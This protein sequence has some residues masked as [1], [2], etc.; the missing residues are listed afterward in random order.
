ME[1]SGWHFWIDRG[2][3]FTDIVARAPDG[4]LRTLKL[5]SENPGRYADAA[6]HGIE[7]VLREEGAQ[8]DIA[9]VKMGTTV[10]TNA[11][12]ER[13]GEPAVL[14]ITAGLKDALRIGTQNR[15]DIFALDIELPEMLYN[16][17]VE[18]HERL[19][20]HG[21]TVRVLDEARL[22]EDLGAAR[23]RGVASVAIV[24][25]HGYRFPR[26]EQR[27]KAIAEALGFEHVSVSHEVSPLMKLVARGDTTLVDAYL[28]PVLFRY[29][30]RV[31]QGLTSAAGSPLLQ[32]MQSNGGLVQAELFRGKDSILSGPAAGVV[33]MA[34]TGR[35]A[36]F[37]QVIGFDMGGTSTDVS[38]YDGDF[39]R[40]TSSLIAGVRVTAP[41]MRINTVAAGGGSILRLAAGRLRVGP[42]S[43]GAFPGPACYRNDGPLAVT[44]ANVVLGRIQPDF[45]P[46]VFGPNGDQPLDAG[47]S[48]RAFEVLARELAA[49][50][51]DHVS[52]DRLAGGF[53]RIAVETM[54]NAIKQVSVQ[55]GHDVTKFV[56]SC[57]GGAGGQHACQ[58][59]DALGIETVLIHPLAGV[60][61]AYGMGLADLR[62]MRQAALEQRLDA[63]C[64]AA[65][66][67]VF[68]RLARD[69]AGELRAQGIGDARIRLERRLR[70]KLTGSDT[71]LLVPWAPGG[72]L[73]ALHGAFHAE[74]ARHFG[75]GAPEG[76]VTVESVEL[77]AVGVVEKPEEPLLARGKEAARPLARRAVWFDGGR[78]D[79]PI[80]ARAML[81]AGAGIEGPAVIVETNATTV[82]EPQWRASVNS[83]GHLTLSRVR[84]RAQHE[85]I[86]T[87]RDPIMLEV[88]N[89]LFMHIAEQM[90]VVLEN[91]AHSVNI[92][93]RLD[94]SCAVFDAEGELIANA[95]HMPVHLGSMGD[96]VRSVLTANAAAM[97]PGNVFMLNAPYN[98]GTHLPDVTVVTPVFGA[99]QRTLEFVVACRAHH[100][101][102][103]GITPG[104][105]PATSRSIEEEG[106]LLDNVA[107]VEE[108]RLEEARIR[109]LLESGPYPARN[110]EQNLADLKAQIAANN[111]GVTELAKMVQRFGLDVV[112]AYMRHIKDNAEQCVRDAIGSLHDGRCVT[113]LDGGER[114]AV[115]VTVDRQRREAVVDFSG[116][117]PMSS[118]NFNAPAAIARAVVL[119]VFRTLI[120][121]DIP[122]NAGC[123]KPLTL[124]LPEASLVNPRYPAAVVAGNVETSQCLTDALLAALGACAAA[125]G[126][127]N[128]LT[129]GNARHQYYETLCGGA[130]AGP[131]FD[132]ASAVHTHMTNSRLTDPEVLEWRYPVRVMRFEIRKGTGGRGAH[133]G[134]DGVV[135]ELEFLEPMQAA[136][137]SNRRRVAP[138]GLN[139]GGD[140]ARGENRVIR[141]DGRE[142]LLGATAELMLEAGD[143][144]IIAT[145]GGGGYGPSS[146]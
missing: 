114:I 83:L 137:L 5:L 103:G 3:T 97:A 62:S 56:L 98:G 79:A 126:T 22:R 112:H 10:A 12:L 92:K 65:L 131:D 14:V 51:G 36:G 74:H 134:G 71:A 42:E 90:G 104:S 13:K 63:A 49:S 57:F 30:E 81:G 44:D 61:S 110:P 130:G 80:Y 127:M 101:D 35:A 94:F 33:G 141:R 116:T 122:L 59:A 75:F 117:S 18:A 108:G 118:T 54:A 121:E 24:L 31:R 38:L 146:D 77:E 4:R 53:L 26:H 120:E 15:P 55:R 40:T 39:E 133:P 145:P 67:G 2:G 96:S 140:G 45:F 29:I 106:V 41:M 91:T 76:A 19:S 48:Q 68:E 129:F 125:Q 46:S 85:A 138:F 32:F 93:E 25:L 6:V 43:A 9:A 143:R 16:S 27:A 21:E 102:I 109:E 69:A 28:S 64:L 135:R 52:V 8:T 34:A 139:G 58:V 115:G 107:I 87:E 37:E 17:V 88:F 136:I 119:Y 128:N 78:V 60:L 70:L 66:D 50:T 73:D 95:P 23:A 11:L 123:L 20:S 47:A 99:D 105:M 113:E 100:A 72:S 82:V 111:K 142:E 124:R 132:G 1:G 7:R 89:N 84:P 144:L 86:G